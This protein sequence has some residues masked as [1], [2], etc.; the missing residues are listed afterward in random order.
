MEWTYR[1]SWYCTKGTEQDGIQKASPREP[2]DGLND[3]NLQSG[4]SR[5]ST[6][7]IG[8]SVTLEE[9]GNDDGSTKEDFKW[10]HAAVG[11][12]VSIA[13]AMDQLV[14][15]GFSWSFVLT[16]VKK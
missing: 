6:W 1:R 9:E 2:Y 4:H 14:V 7:H 8:F 15:K 3:E 11:F 5:I 12:W 13:L 16:R 10:S